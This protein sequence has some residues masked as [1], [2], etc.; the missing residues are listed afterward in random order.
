MI[1]HLSLILKISHKYFSVCCIT[2]FSKILVK[3]TGIFLFSRCISA[4]PA[5][6]PGQPGEARNINGDIHAR[7][8]GPYQCED[9]YRW[10]RRE[11]VAIYGPRAW[12]DVCIWNAFA[13]TYDYKPGTCPEGT[14][15]LNG[16]IGPGYRF[17]SCISEETGKAVSGQ[18]RKTDPQVGT[19]S[20]KKGRTEIGNTQQK[21][22][23]AVDHDMTGASVAA[24]F[25]SR[26]RTFVCS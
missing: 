19:S 18:K 2:M 12:Q 1:H 17:I 7:A 25:E 3:L 16:F 13:T 21:F 11:C 8:Y 14:T 24:V 9:P 4:T 5:T 20:I 26:C 15:C 23:V 10:I 22:S 6:P